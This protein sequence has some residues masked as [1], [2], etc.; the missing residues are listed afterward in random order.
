[1]T[2]EVAVAAKGGTI[3]GASLFSQLVIFTDHSY[4]YLAIVGSFVSMFGVLHTI[5]TADTPYDIKSVF[6]E[7]I[8]GI[9]LGF[10]AIPFWYLVITEGLLDNIIHV[11]FNTVS[12][13]LALIISFAA[14]WNTVPIYNWLVGLV[15]RKGS[16]NAR[17]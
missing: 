3:A 15:K 14:S 10:L 7:I 12:N 5:F 11:E 17:T 2:D 4:M 1:M 8:K 9:S 16:Y 13:S 6:G